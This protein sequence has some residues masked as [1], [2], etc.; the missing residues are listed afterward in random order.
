MG[1]FTARNIAILALIQVGVIVVGVLAAMVTLK[2][3][4]TFSASSGSWTNTLA[5]YGWLAILLPAAWATL[6][7]CILA[8]EESS[9]H[10][11]VL[12]VLGGFLL[13]VALLW[14]TWMAAIREWLALVGH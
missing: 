9:S 1:Y 2:W 3:R 13:L 4:S 8:R 7:L 12:V 14:I 5:G 10:A 11:R 6:A